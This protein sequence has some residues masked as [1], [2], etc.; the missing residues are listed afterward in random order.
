MTAPA[1]SIS[2]ATNSSV[3]TSP[4]T[5]FSGDSGQTFDG[6]FD[7]MVNSASSS[8]FED[9]FRGDQTVALEFAE[10]FER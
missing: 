7:S 5:N 4:L 9:I 1:D 8:T 2:S 3:A 6:E 10:K